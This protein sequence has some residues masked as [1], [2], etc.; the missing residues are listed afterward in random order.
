VS[1][2]QRRLAT[3]VPGVAQPVLQLPPRQCVQRGERLV[4][5]EKR[6]F[7]QQRAQQRDT[8]PHA[9]RELR[10]MRRFEALQP[11][12]RQQLARPCAR[13]AARAGTRDLQSQGGVVQDVAPGEQQ[14]LLEHVTAA[15]T[16]RVRVHIAPHRYLAAAWLQDARDQVE[17]RALTA[18]GRPDDRDEVAGFDFEGDVAQRL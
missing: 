10:R 2:Q 9:A 17:Q 4:K 7:Q 12:P 1:D 14:V 5:Q 6:P 15:Q 3:G 11:E 16:P 18:A 13:L 8:L